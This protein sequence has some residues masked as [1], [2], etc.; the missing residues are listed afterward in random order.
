MLYWHGV[1]RETIREILVG[2]PMRYF[3]FEE[4]EG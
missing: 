1:E 3:M 2:N 4:P